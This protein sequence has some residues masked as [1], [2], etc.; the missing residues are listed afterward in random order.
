MSRSCRLAQSEWNVMRTLWASPDP[1]PASEVIEALSGK[2][3]W[4]PRT[5]KTLLGRLVRK[6]ALGF[7]TRG[8]AYLYYP[9]VSESDCLKAEGARF[10]R[11]CFDGALQPMLAHFV[12]N[13]RLSPSDMDELKRVIEQQ[14]AKGRFRRS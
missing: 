9:R 8:K 4:H 5:I 13:Y 11:K 2:T 3:A 12:R 10:L 6:G 7:K 14:E 1:M